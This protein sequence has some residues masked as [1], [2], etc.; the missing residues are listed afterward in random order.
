MFWTR[1]SFKF[2]FGEPIYQKSDQRRMVHGQPPPL[3]YQ[4]IDT[5]SQNVGTVLLDDADRH[6]L[7]VGRHGFIQIAEAQYFGIDGEVRD[8][9]NCPLYL[10][11][12]VV[13]D[14][15][16]EVTY[17]LRLRRVQKASWMPAGPGLK[18]VCLAS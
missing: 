13:W 6:W 11:M 7:D 10:V 12:L 4:L 3:R 15:S 17:R 8:V 14:E 5:E 16:F 1:S 18:F 2:R 9:E